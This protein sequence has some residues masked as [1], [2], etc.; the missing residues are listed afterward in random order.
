[1]HFV[2]QVVVIDPS[3]VKSLTLVGDGAFGGGGCGSLDL[4]SGMVER[5]MKFVMLNVD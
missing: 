1:M 5:M 4:D 2:G 3:N